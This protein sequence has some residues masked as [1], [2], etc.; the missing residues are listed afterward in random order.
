[1]Q[2]PTCQVVLLQRNIWDLFSLLSRR[3]NARLVVLK[4]RLLQNVH[5]K[6]FSC[7]HEVRANDASRNRRP[8][9]M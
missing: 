4:T 5:P 8:V 6:C 9:N 1:M 7:E 2:L 3:P